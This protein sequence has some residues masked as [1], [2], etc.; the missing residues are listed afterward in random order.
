VLRFDYDGTG[1]AAGDELDPDRWGA[2]QRSVHHAVDELLHASGVTDVCLLGVR[3]GATIAA[4]AAPTRDDVAGL[5][6]IAPVLSGKFWLREMRAVQAAMGRP[7]PPAEF[8][9]PEGVLE[10]VGLLMPAETRTAIGAVDLETL[11]RPP[12]AKCL[13]IDRDDRPP[14]PAVVRSPGPARGICRAPGP[15]GLRRNGA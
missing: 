14:H 12:A 5:A 7:Q 11:E 6:V 3:L 2:W 13:V 10:T 4:L 8:A 9:L 1:D 15:A